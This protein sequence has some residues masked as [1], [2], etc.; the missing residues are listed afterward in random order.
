[1]VASSQRRHLVV[2]AFAK[3]CGDGLPLRTEARH[4]LLARSQD[5]DDDD[6]NDTFISY[7]E[8]RRLL[9]AAVLHHGSDHYPMSKYKEAFGGRGRE[10]G[11]H[12][13][14]R[15]RRSCVKCPSKTSEHQMSEMKE[16]LA[17]GM[18]PCSLTSGLP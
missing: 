8:F 3:G 17:T 2:E 16:E 11:L 12:L 10:E 18:A 15:A 14:V 5:D 1:M 9:S 13:R 6:S 4:D 7:Q